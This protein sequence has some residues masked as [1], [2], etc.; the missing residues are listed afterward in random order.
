MKC[1]CVVLIVY[2]CVLIVASNDPCCTSNAFET[3]LSE[4]GGIYVSNATTV[5]IDVWNKMYYDFNRKMMTLETHTRLSTGYYKQ[6]KIIM[7]FRQQLEFAIEKGNCTVIPVKESM[8]KPCIPKNATYLGSNSIGYADEAIEFTSWEFETP[9][10][11]VST[12]LTVSSKGCVPLTQSMYVNRGMCLH[13]TPNNKTAVSYTFAN[14]KP[15]ITND[16]VFQIPANCQQVHSH[17]AP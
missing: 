10:S 2:C 1:L 6:I 12:K 7:D 4:A 17:I 15:M 5:P 14:F 16:A 11:D 13:T 8:Q 9:N 3:V